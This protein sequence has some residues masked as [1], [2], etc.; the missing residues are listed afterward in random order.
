MPRN[1][2][3]VAAIMRALSARKQADF[4]SPAGTGPF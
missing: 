1:K 3:T 2:R 4:A